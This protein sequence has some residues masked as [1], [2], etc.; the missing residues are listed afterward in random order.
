M[1]TESPSRTEVATFTFDSI[2]KAKTQNGDEQARR[3]SDLIK[4]GRIHL[5]PV[6]KI[7]IGRREKAVK[8]LESTRGKVANMAVIISEY[9]FSGGIPVILSTMMDDALED[10]SRHIGRYEREGID[11]QPAGQEDLEAIRAFNFDQGL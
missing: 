6:P 9:Q 11:L 8:V 7:V 2:L 10:A 1:T 4:A 5:V 3:V